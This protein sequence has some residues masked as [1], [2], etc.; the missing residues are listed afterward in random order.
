MGNES[1]ELQRLIAIVGAQQQSIERL[2]RLV[3]KGRS[4]ADDGSAKSAENDD[5]GEKEKEKEKEKKPRSVDWLTVTGRERLLAWQGLAQ[6]VEALVFRFNMQL[7][8][9]PCWWMHPEAVEELTAIWHTHQE[10]HSDD[11]GL[12]GA[13]SWVDAMHKS[14]ERL[15]SMFQP[16]RERHVDAQM[17]AR[18]WMTDAIRAEFYETVRRDVTDFRRST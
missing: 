6:F 3:E 7:V 13:M 2:V 11:A 12:Q 4:T 16:C 17:S 9:R 1:A 8:V 18:V 15:R 10:T 5:K 14:I